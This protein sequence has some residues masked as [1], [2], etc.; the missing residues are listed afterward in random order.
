MAG[1]GCDNFILDYQLN[2]YYKD[3]MKEVTYEADGVTVKSSTDL[4]YS[5]F[6]IS[7][8]EIDLIFG[9]IT[10]APADGIQISRTYSVNYLK[11]GA[12]ARLNSGSPGYRINSA[13]KVGSLSAKPLTAT[14]TIQT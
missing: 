3:K 5:S 14:A 6:E 2:I 9:S 4:S 7:K 11:D 13:L 12:N 10:A 8:I 1:G